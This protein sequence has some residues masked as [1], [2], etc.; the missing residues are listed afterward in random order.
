MSIL[1]ASDRT[2]LRT[3][4]LDAFPQY[5]DLEIFVSDRLD[6]RLNQFGDGKALT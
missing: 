3:A 5:S 2:Q 1:S 4:L 6:L